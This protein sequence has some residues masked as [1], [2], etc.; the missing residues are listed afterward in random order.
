MSLVFPGKKT[1]G[2]NGYVY[3][4]MLTFLFLLPS[5]VAAR[6]ECEGTQYCIRVWLAVC[7][8]A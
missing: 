4:I 1:S 7:P 3:N 6:E 5:L 8:D 2:C